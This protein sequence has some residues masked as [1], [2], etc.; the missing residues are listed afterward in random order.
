MATTI[1]YDQVLVGKIDITDTY[2]KLMAASTGVD[3]V[4]IKAKETMQDFYT[5]NSGL[6]DMQKA[7]LMSQMIAE[8]AKSVT[9]E[10]MQLALKID[11]DNR[12]APYMLTKLK[13]D[14]MQVEATIL[15]MAADV[16]IAKQQLI[17]ETVNGWNIQAQGY[18]DLGIQTWNQAVGTT[19]LPESAYITYGTKVTS[20]EKSNADIY[21]LYSSA[22]RQFGSVNYTLNPDGTPL[23]ITGDAHGLT[24]WQT[25]VAAR[26]KQGFE[27]NQRQHVVNSSASM[28]SMLLTANVPGIDYTPYLTAYSNASTYLQTDHNISV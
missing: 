14:T 21:A 20:I 5:S 24:Y 11:T 23:T 16:D 12:D 15:K 13:A 18:R 25:A 28:V 6:T 4:Y 10:A 2:T 8:I 7:T 19:I 3:S 27:D 22:Y 1:T 9:S 26:Q 17:N